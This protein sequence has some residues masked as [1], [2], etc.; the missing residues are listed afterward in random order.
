M[1]FVEGFGGRAL[2]RLFSCK[3]T[4]RFASDESRG[5][6][7]SLAPSAPN[8][9][10]PSLSSRNSNTP[11]GGVVN[12]SSS[13]SPLGPSTFS[14]WPQNLS[15]FTASQS[16]PNL[17]WHDSLSL[18]FPGGPCGGKLSLSLSASVQSRGVTAPDGTISTAH[19]PHVPSPRQFIAFAPPL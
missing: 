12:P 8:A 18:A 1:G 3:T 11:S 13:S 9:L 17:T 15:R 16:P 19:V 6:V 10:L 5:V 14:P 4:S 2:R 7:V